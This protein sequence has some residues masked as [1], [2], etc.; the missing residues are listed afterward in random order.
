MEPPWLVFG[1]AE[2]AEAQLGA[3]YGA[4]TEEEYCLRKAALE[5]KRWRLISWSRSLRK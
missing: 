1:A 4:K 5:R 3:L 2:L